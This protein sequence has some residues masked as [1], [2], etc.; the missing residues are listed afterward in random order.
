LN[1]KK[2]RGCISTT[3]LQTKKGKHKGREVVRG[4]RERERKKG[5]NRI[6]EEEWFVW[7]E[8]EEKLKKHF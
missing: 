4:E 5:E 1:E 8:R 6:H 7:D 3:I 2:V